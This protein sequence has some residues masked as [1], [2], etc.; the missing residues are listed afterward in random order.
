M[1]IPKPDTTK[2]KDDL[3]SPYREYRNLINEFRNQPL[4]TRLDSIT[5]ERI[6]RPPKTDGFDV[7]TCAFKD[8]VKWFKEPYHRIHNG[9]NGKKRKSQSQVGVII[10]IMAWR[11]PNELA[12]FK[13][14]ETFPIK[15]KAEAEMAESNITKEFEHI[16]LRGYC[17]TVR[18]DGFLTNSRNKQLKMKNGRI[19][20]VRK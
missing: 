8:L 5:G 7:E 1:N 20:I 2:D 14:Q 16:G 12:N 10:D 13:R 4:Q 3:Y 18:Q 6:D 19:K 11:F 17:G 9:A 15:L